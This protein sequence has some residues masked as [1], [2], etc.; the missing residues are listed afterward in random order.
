MKQKKA[1]NLWVVLGIVGV[2][3]ILGVLNNLRVFD[4]QRVKWFGGPVIEVEEDA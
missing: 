2:A 4:E 3:V 1:F